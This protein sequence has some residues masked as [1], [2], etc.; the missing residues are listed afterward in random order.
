MCDVH[1]LNNI[2]KLF[3]GASYKSIP[4]KRSPL[5]KA[6]SGNTSILPGKLTL[7]N[8]TLPRVSSLIAMSTFF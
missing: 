4:S 3:P 2:N 7:R 8:V 5:A 6:P 1:I